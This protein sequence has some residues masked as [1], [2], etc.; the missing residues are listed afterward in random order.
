MLLATLSLAM[1]ANQQEPPRTN[2]PRAER[3]A[4]VSVQIMS[5]EEIRFDQN[6]K[7]ERGGRQQLR[8]FR[9]RAGM[10]MVEFY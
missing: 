8:Q 7:A 5:A 10:P 9:N 2:F 1:I 6:L 3:V 4:R